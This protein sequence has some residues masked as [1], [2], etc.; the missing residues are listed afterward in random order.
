MDASEADK[1]SL[2]HP[3]SFAGEDSL[4]WGHGFSSE[5]L[6][7][8]TEQQEGPGAHCRLLLMNSNQV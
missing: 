5:H 3:E 8:P 7:Q 1:E 2:Y 6:P 4:K